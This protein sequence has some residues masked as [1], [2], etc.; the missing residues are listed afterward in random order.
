MGE[1]PVVSGFAQREVQPD[2]VLGNLE[3][4]AELGDV[5]RHQDRCAVRDQGQA[6]VGPG[7]DLAGELTDALSDLA[8]EHGPGE[9]LGHSDHRA[10]HRLHLFRDGRT[11]GLD[12][13]A[14]DGLDEPLPGRKRSLHPLGAA[15]G[16]RAR[17]GSREAG[18][19]V[20]PHLG[21]AYG[22][23]DRAPLGVGH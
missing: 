12:D 3:A 7:D 9:L 1:Q 19:A 22:F 13:L 21:K 23:V 15:P 8:A 5:L 16:L 10:S 17:G 2:L 4:G 6:D 18:G 11:R 20:E 14:C